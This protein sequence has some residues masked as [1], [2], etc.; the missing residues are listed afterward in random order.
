[1]EID[2]YSF[3]Y[4]FDHSGFLYVLAE[5]INQSICMTVL[6]VNYEHVQYLLRISPLI[7]N[8]YNSISIIAM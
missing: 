1:M 2:G 6:N 8:M 3:F 5:S 4:S 7:S